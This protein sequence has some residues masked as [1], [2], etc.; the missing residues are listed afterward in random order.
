MK[1][2]SRLLQT[3]K[4]SAARAETGVAPPRRSEA[5]PKRTLTVTITPAVTFES[6][7]AA[8][9]YFVGPRCV[10]VCVRGGL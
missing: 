1:L 6:G 2:A 8:P 5:H 4:I 7:A 3:R 10:F 9:G